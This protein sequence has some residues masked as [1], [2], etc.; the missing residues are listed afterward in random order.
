ML[1]VNLGN[2]PHT[3]APGDRI[4]QLVIAPVTRATVVEV[5]ELSE[6]ERGAGGFGHTG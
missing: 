3:L 2:A 5:A 6:T 4:A 1:L